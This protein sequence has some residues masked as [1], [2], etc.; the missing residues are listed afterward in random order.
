MLVMVTDWKCSEVGPDC[1]MCH[2]EIPT[3]SLNQFI[4]E[5]LDVIHVANF[6]GSIEIIQDTNYTG[7]A[8]CTGTGAAEQCVG[9]TA[10]PCDVDVNMPGNAG[11]EGLPCKPQIYVNVSYFGVNQDVTRAIAVDAF[12]KDRVL[13]VTVGYDHEEGGWNT[14]ACPEAHVRLVLSNITSSTPG[15]GP[16]LNVTLG[17]N[18]PK[19]EAMWEPWLGKKMA[20]KGFIEATFDPAM[21]F[22]GVHITNWVPGGNISVRGVATTHLALQAASGNVSVLGVDSSSVIALAGDDGRVDISEAT[23]VAMPEITRQEGIEEEMNSVCRNVN[24]PPCRSPRFYYRDE[25]T[26]QVRDTRIKFLSPQHCTGH[27]V[28]IRC[29]H[30]HGPMLH[31]LGVGCDTQGKCCMDRYLQIARGFQ[32]HGSLHVSTNKGH[33]TVDKVAGHPSIDLSSLEGSIE[34]LLE[35]AAFSGKTSDNSKNRIKGKL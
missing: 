27:Q 6:R 20:H 31:S 25:E 35:S 33:I 34:L 11:A 13:R 23:L 10:W 3:S 24:L 14:G 8:D 12:L 1:L 30:V 19:R 17:H 21:V 9:A 4:G 15:V 16:V 26:F 18:L 28:F 5:N 32:P 29:T 7:L 2:T 22:G